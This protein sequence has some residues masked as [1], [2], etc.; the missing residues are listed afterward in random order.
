M[1]S[2]ACCQMNDWEQEEDR[3]VQHFL[4]RGQLLWKNVYYNITVTRAWIKQSSMSW[5]TQVPRHAQPTHLQQSLGAEHVPDLPLP[6]IYAL[7]RVLQHKTAWRSPANHH[8]DT[9]TF[10]LSTTLW[11]FN[12]TCPSLGP[13]VKGARFCRFNIF[14]DPNPLTWAPAAPCHPLSCQR[15]SS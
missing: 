12:Y 3:K 15:E 10:W 9:F 4:E 13:A 6:D 11:N 14:R 8:Q 2:A 1:Q 5:S 7:S